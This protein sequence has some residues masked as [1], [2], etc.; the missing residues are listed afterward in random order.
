MNRTLPMSTQPPDNTPGP[1]DQLALR[2][3]RGALDSPHPADEPFVM[4]NRESHVIAKIRWQT[5]AMAGLFGILGVVL[6]YVPQYVWPAFF[7]P[8]ALPILTTTYELPLVTLL[9]GVLLVYLEI[10]ALLYINLRAVRYVMAVC[11]FP[12]Q[13]DAQY[14]RHLHALADAAQEKENRSMLRF[15]INPY[16]GLPQWGLT[17][18]FMVN[19]LKAALS[20]VVLKFL[21]KRLL[22]R[23]GLRQVTD[24]AGMPIYAFWN[25]WASDQVIHEAKIRVMAPLTI[26][27]FVDSLHEEWKHNQAFC[28]L[29]PEA[30]QYVAIL[31]RQYNYAHLLL[32]ETLMDRF[33]LKVI[34]PT[35]HFLDR[36][37]EAPV[38]VRRPLERLIIF[39][40]LIDGGISWFEKRRLRQFQQRGWL[41][42]SIEE[43]EEIGREYYRGRGLWV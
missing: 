30:L 19:K 21:L 27:E 26:R 13:H 8:T 12:R 9:Y 14:E 24:L 23:F 5:L 25:I 20:N 42:Y 10:Y 35:G 43:I 31:K 37:A 1:I 40:V 29:I 41:S 28:E 38:E 15:G 4:N 11:Q 16:L 22:G 7:E 34:Q 2:Y 39:G 17:A 32:T 36:L 3:L 18:F 33:G 6:L